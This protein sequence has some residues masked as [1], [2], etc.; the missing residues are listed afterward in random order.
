MYSRKPLTGATGPAV[1]ADLKDIVLKGKRIDAEKALR[2][3]AKI[4]GVP[5]LVPGT[6]ELVRRT[7]Q[8]RENVLARHVASYDIAADGKI[9]YSNGSGVFLRWT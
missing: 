4:G 9:I 8:G 5:S 6:W 2:T 1:Q 7:P 3:G